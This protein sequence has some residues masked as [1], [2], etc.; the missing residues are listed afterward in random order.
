MGASVL[1]CSD[2]VSVL[3]RGGASGSRGMAFSVPLPFLRLYL[4]AQHF[5]LSLLLHWAE[6]SP[7]LA[8][9]A[10]LL[11]LQWIFVG[12]LSYFFFFSSR[13][14]REEGFRW[15]CVSSTVAPHIQTS[16]VKDAFSGLLL[17][18]FW[19]RKR[20]PGGVCGERACKGARSSH[21]ADATWGPAFSCQPIFGLRPCA[22]YST[23]I[24]F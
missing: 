20:Q 11:W 6:S 3:G 16:T 4:W 23:P 2:Q 18:S 21:I 8:H 15:T 22:N 1:C 19:R 10:L 13:G 24:I 7:H 14:H 9:S 5:F 17:I 12:C